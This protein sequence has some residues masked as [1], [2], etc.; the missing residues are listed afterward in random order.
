MTDLNVLKTKY[1]SFAKRSQSW[2]SS[3]LALLGLL[4]AGLTLS[5]H[6]AINTDE[7]NFLINL[8]SSTNGVDWT[9]REGWC[10]RPDGMCTASDPSEFGLPGTECTW[11]GITCDYGSYSQHVIDIHLPNNNLIGYLPSFTDGAGS[12][13]SFP[14]TK[15]EHFNVSNNTLMGTIPDI[16]LLPALMGFDVRHNA[17]HGSIP[18]ASSSGRL[19]VF[20]AADNQLTGGIPEI[21]YLPYMIEF[22]VSNNQL[23]GPIPS[24]SGLSHLVTFYAHHNSLSGSIPSLRETTSLQ[25]FDVSHNLLTG[26]PPPPPLPSMLQATIC[27]NAL[28]HR[29]D[30]KDR[31]NQL[32]NSYWDFRTNV[33]PPHHWWEQGKGCTS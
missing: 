26:S 5:A 10:R 9:H 8:Y 22:D 24:L 29:D 31:D 15:L 17:L 1:N 2:R 23:S 12:F 27:P 30:P 16:S 18:A 33:M 25:W 13:D 3:A 32:L 28:T 7:R 20:L 6:A 14:F 21:S 4:V 19:T 11:L